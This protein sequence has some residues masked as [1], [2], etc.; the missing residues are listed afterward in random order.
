MALM[1]TASPSSRF[2]PPPDPPPYEFPMVE[3][4]SLITPPE[5][6]DPPDAVYLFVP[7]QILN[8]SAKPSLQEFTQTFIL[9]LACSTMMTKLNGGGAPFVSAGDIP[10]AYGRLFPVVYMYHCR[11]ADLSSLR[12]YLG[13]PLPPPR[14]VLQVHICLSLSDYSVEG[15]G[16]KVVWNTLDMWSLVLVDDVLMDRLSFSSTLVR[17]LLA[18]CMFFVV[19]R[20][21]FG[22]VILFFSSWWQLEG[23]LIGMFHLVNMLLMD[24]DF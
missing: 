12:S 3:G 18:V 13:L 21:A 23:K 19:S 17:S 16:M 24:M 10:F 6:Q 22:A 1:V 4:F 7:L 5:P 14:T 20:L 8:T 9:M 11:G 15:V 2:R